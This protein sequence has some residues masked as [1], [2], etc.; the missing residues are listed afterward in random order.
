MK[1]K[2]IIYSLALLLP[3]ATG[4][5]S[6][7]DV[8]PLDPNINTADVVYSKPENYKKGLFKIY[9]VLAMS[10]QDGSGSSDIDGLDAGNAQFYR[11]MWNL[12]V[13]TTDECINSWPDPWVPEVNEMNWTAVGN[14]SIE[15]T[16]QRAMFIVALANEYLS[17]TTDGNMS[18]RGIEESFF[19]TVHGFRSE[20]R[21]MRALSYFYLMDMY[22][23]P[24]FI[25]ELN[26]ST[27]PGQ[28][29]REALFNWIEEE[30]LAIKD[31]L[32]EAKTANYYGRADKGVVNA[33]LSRMYL[34]AEVYTGSARWDDCIKVSKELIND[35][36]FGLTEEYSHLFMADNN[37]PEVTKEIIFPIVYEATRTQT[38]GGMTFLIAASRGNDEVS[39]EN[40]GTKNGWSGNRALSNLVKK[41]AYKNQDTPKADEINDKRGIFYDANRSIDIETSYTKTFE[42]EG[43]AVYKYTNLKSDDTPGSN[44]THPDTDIPLFRLAEVYLNYA[45]AVLRGGQGGSKTEALQL[46]NKLRE[47]GYGSNLGNI[48]ESDLTLNFLLDERA[49]ELYWEG[50][51]RTDLVRYGLFTSNKYVW[52][53]KGGVKQGTG[54]E[55]FRNVYPIPSTDL[56]VNTSLEQNKGY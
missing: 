17:Q 4:C 26:H 30:L 2:N 55:E 37:R 50:I 5:V 52:Q 33:L 39:V 40:S 36:N 3:L 18:S 14:E 9:S 56:S 8:S 6:D 19:E 7:L 1:V 43:W 34:N 54:I 28:I 21:F 35:G 45:E 49:R 31:L 12:Q 47:R 38:Y 44:D 10:G 46:V 41:F 16:Y 51:R 29:G 13:G 48:S 11:S 22:G 42:T 27:A 53:F 23:N 25:T 24:P 32:P 20:A 15:G